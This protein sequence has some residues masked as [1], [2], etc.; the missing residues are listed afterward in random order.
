MYELEVLISLTAVIIAL[1]GVIYFMFSD[2]RKAK[3]LAYEHRKREETIKDRYS[4]LLTKYY[5]SMKIVDA[6]NSLQCG[7]WGCEQPIDV[8][9]SYTSDKTYVHAHCLE[10]N[11]QEIPEDRGHKELWRRK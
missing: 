5:E 9:V 10:H 11:I 3:K 7:V 6:F 4:N 2:L 1:L 8:I